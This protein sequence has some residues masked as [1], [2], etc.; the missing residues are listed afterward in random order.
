ML[1][2]TLQKS[3]SQ[4]DI[5][6]SFSSESMGIT[7]LAGPSGS[8]KS[9]IINMIAGL[10]TP[11][12]GHIQINDR[13]LFDSD[14]KNNIPVQ[15]RRCGYIFQNSRL[16]PN[17]NVHR[18]LL[19]GKHSN[20]KKLN[21]IASLLGIEHLLKRMP[22]NLSGGEKQRVAIGRALL[23][24]PQILLMDEPL[25]SLDFER[26]EELLPYISN[27]PEQFNIPVFYV[28]HSRNEI[29]R[30]SDFLV[31]ID[32]G[33]IISCGKPSGEYSELGSLEGSEKICSIFDCH[34]DNYRPEYGVIT[35]TFPGNEIFILA[36]QKPEK[37]TIRASIRASDVSIALDKPDNISTRNIF[38]ATITEITD[39]PKH[40]VLVHTDAGVPICAQISRASADR[41][42]LQPGKKV[43]LMIKTV[44]LSV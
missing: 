11:D 26:K 38:K 5:D 29:L 6:V 8:G 43:F 4:F 32:N 2:I 42:K 15:H 37:N 1:V 31:R 22:E 27:L 30:L 17:M 9:S 16:F 44:A 33:K 36:D 34:V 35:A 14:S 25:S 13:I 18:N 19:Y 40:S 10:V 21:E 41:L 3:F 28:T 24:S 20:S 39:A 23:M 7:V 12:Q